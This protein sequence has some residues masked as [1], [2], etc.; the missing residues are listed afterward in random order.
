MPMKEDRANQSRRGEERHVWP[1]PVL[2]AAARCTW[3]IQ[4]HDAFLLQLPIKFQHCLQSDPA[5]I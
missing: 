5:V 3:F 4:K 1:R 2:Q